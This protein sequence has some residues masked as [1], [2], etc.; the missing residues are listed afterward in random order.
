MTTPTL[1]LVSAG[2]ATHVAPWAA[3]TTPVLR[4]RARIDTNAWIKSLRLVP[5]GDRTMRQRFTYRDDSLWWFTEL[6]LQKMRRL[7]TARL[8]VLAL[9]E[10]RARFAP[11]RLTLTHADAPTAAAARAW[12]AARGVGVALPG[13]ASLSPTAERRQAAAVG[14]SAYAARLLR[15]R[16]RPAPAAIAAFVHTAF[17]RDQ[18]GYIGPVLDA[19]AARAGAGALHLIGVGPRRAFAARAGAPGAHASAHPALTTIEALSPLSA[20]RGSLA[21]WR[22]RDALADDVTRGDAIR[23]AARVDDVDLWPVLE[24]DLRG[25][26]LVQ[27]PWSARTM[28]EAGAAI[29]ALGCHTV[30]TYAEAGGVGRALM[31]EARRRGVRSIGLQ[32][33]FIYR[34]WLNYRHEADEITAEADDRGYP[35]PDLTL[36][37][38]RYA[39]AHLREAGH[40]PVDRLVVTGSARLDAL[41]ARITRLTAAEITA[42]REAVGAVPGQRLALLAAKFSE[43]REDLPALVDAVKAEPGIHLAIKA[44]PSESADLYTALVDGV[45]NISVAAADA[46]LATLV[47]AADVVV[48]KNS[49]V[50]LDGLVLGRPALVIGLPNNLSPFVDAGVMAGAATPEAVGPALRGV[51]Y[52]RE[53]RDRLTGAAAAFIDAYGLRASGDAADRAARIITA[54]R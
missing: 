14:W 7:E 48:T 44:H 49:T 23:A 46:D 13:A 26:A 32:H 35:L 39:E 33:G 21:L 24:A 12:G 25:A 34:H 4:E 22:R 45:R 3:C 1:T 52:D 47:G 11:A 50:A 42:A 20:L 51:L 53:V 10:A 38:D 18:D 40:F 17:V 54:E 31:L 28:D 30:V 41:A 29:D 15:R 27:W 2:G 19:V 8:T 36:V 37:F 5:Y 9:D 6:Y 43:I 16:S